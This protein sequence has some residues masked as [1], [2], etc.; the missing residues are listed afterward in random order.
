MGA[1]IELHFPKQAEENVWGT[2]QDPK[3]SALQG[4]GRGKGVLAEVLGTLQEIEL[5]SGGRT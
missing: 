4:D 1:D 5:T 3:T 2:A